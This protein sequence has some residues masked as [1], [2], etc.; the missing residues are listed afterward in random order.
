MESWFK[1]QFSVSKYGKAR[2]S[3]TAVRVAHRRAKASNAQKTA[4][5]LSIAHQYRSNCDMSQAGVLDSFA[6][7]EL[8]YQG[9]P[10]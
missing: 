6:M 1:K 2:V 7:G 9:Q 10:Y 8:R 5:V 4:L 3:Q